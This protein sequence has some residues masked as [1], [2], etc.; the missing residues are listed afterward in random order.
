R[1]DQVFLFKRVMREAALRHDVYA[2][3]MAKPMAAE[4]GSSMHVHQ[5]LVDIRSGE[6]VFSGTREGGLSDTFMHYLA[7]LQHYIPAAMA[8]F[9]PNV[10]SY[11]RIARDES[12]PINVQWGFDN[13]TAGLRVPHSK[14]ESTR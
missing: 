6:N 14:P 10:N 9:A 7:G 13:R 2:T 4:P 1:A 11:R 8:I 12:A 5:S 3:F